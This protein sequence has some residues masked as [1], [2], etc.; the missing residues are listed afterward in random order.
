MK[1]KIFVPF[2]VLFVFVFCSFSVLA[3]SSEFSYL[4]K[5]YA[6]F[7]YA[8]NK[9]MPDYNRTTDEASRTMSAISTAPGQYKFNSCTYYWKF[10]LN[11]PS[12]DQLLNFT[13][14]GTITMG[15]VE[16]LS[17]YD[18]GFFMVDED[19]WSPVRCGDVHLTR[20]KN[21]EF[22]F[23]ADCSYI[24]D[25]GQFDTTTTLLFFF[26]TNNQYYYYF[27]QAIC[28]SDSRLTNYYWGPSDKDNAPIYPG[29][30]NGAGIVSDYTS[31]DDS[32]MDSTTSGLDS[33]KGMLDDIPDK[34]LTLQGSFLGIVS[35][36]NLICDL[37]FVSFLLF[38]S[39]CLGILALVFNLGSSLLAADGSRMRSEARNSRNNRSHRRG[40]GG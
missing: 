16:R 8:G 40:R 35:L 7:V 31:A 6:V 22:R 26:S 27:D 3:A 36:F 14:S 29:T 33:Y 4:L 17:T 11:T 1:K 39:L 23:S 19:N 30:P 37:P 12:P 21:G 10:N 2:F 5:P 25:S 34:I 9:D 20:V 24:F 18:V 38:F 32:L 15:N 13:L 28:V